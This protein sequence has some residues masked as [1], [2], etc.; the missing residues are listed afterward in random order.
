MKTFLISITANYTIRQKLNGVRFAQCNKTKRFVKLDLAQSELNTEIKK[1][2]KV[3]KISTH[4]IKKYKQKKIV[5][6]SYTPIKL[7]LILLCLLCGYVFGISLTHISCDIINN[8]EN[9]YNQLV[10]FISSLFLQI[11]VC[12]LHGV[13]SINIKLNT[14]S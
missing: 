6:N 10:F 7:I 11:S 13:D 12:Y 8:I 5:K 2:I 14:D 3:K 4:K 9:S 1:K